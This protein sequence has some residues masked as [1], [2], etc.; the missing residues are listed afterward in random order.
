MLNKF[1]KL[2]L[3]YFAYLPLF[4]IIAIN[5]IPTIKPLLITISVLVVVGF[6]FVILLLRVVK[7]ITA[8]QEKITIQEMKNA[9]YLGFLVT[10]ILP[11]LVSLANLREAISFVLL[12]ILIAYLYM[13]TS[14]FGVNPLLKIFFRYNIYEVTMGEGRYFL[15]SKKKYNPRRFDLDVK[16]MGGNIL[17]E[18]E[19]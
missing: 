18:D 3:F 17:I 12:F 10:Y 5:N 15:L 16:L 6:L 1:S 7:S 19:E 9:E 11:F 2:V 8:S 13:D 14:L 4:I